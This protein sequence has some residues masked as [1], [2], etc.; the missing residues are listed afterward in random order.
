[1]KN[2]FII[3]GAAGTGKSDLL[4]YIEEKYATGGVAAVVKKCSTRPL[5][6]EEKGSQ[7]AD[8][9]LISAPDFEFRTSNTRFYHYKY[10]DF[11]YG[12]ALD[13]VDRQLA[14]HKN[15]FI[16]VRDMTTIRRLR[17]H[18][19]WVR[20]IPVF[21]YSDEAEIRKRLVREG[22]SAK[23][24]AWRLS[25]Q[26]T[27][28]NDYLAHSD[29][30]EEVVLNNSKKVDFVRLI[31]NLISKYSR[32]KD[33]E[34]AVSRLERSRQALDRLQ[35]CDNGAPHE[36]REECFRHDEVSSF[37]ERGYLDFYCRNPERAR[38]QP[39]ES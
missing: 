6:P 26:K 34:I 30:Y 32:H 35:S 16:I 22:Y 8:L 21:V 1:M 12:F 37:S 29:I 28:W 23:A 19:F 38:F 9:Q 13:D 5:R 14:L 24:I 27:A 2:L 4:E 20:V 10:G 33:T 39:G 36:L 7:P 18:Y 31:D 17:E 11:R 25:R 15:V 3:D